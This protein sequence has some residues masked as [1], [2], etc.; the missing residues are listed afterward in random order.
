MG[1]PPKEVSEQISCRAMQQLVEPWESLGG[2]SRILTSDLIPNFCGH[3]CPPTTTIDMPIPCNHNDRHDLACSRAY[4]LAT[5][6]HAGSLTEIA[7]PFPTPSLHNRTKNQ[8]SP[9]SFQKEIVPGSVADL[10]TFE[11]ECGRCSIWRLSACSSACVWLPKVACC[12]ARPGPHLVT[13]PGHTD[14]RS[15]L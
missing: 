14:S 3:P 7:A 8:H 4:L 11:N 5:C 9:K 10:S 2:A 1:E 15:W 13:G 12:G 6:M